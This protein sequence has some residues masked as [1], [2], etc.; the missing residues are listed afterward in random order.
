MTSFQRFA[1]DSCTAMPPPSVI[2][3][4]LKSMVVEAGRVQQRVE[5]RIDAAR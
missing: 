4:A 1:T 5:Q 2:F 3:S